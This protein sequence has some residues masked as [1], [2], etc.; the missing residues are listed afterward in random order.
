MTSVVIAAHNEAAVLG[1][2]LDALLAGAAPGEF[3]V[4][5]V[6][7]G[8]T[9]ETVQVAAGRAGVRVVEID[10]ASKPAALNAGDQVAVGFPRIY[11]DADIVLRAEGV[12]ALAAALTEMH[13]AAEHAAAE[14]A[15]GGHGASGH[16]RA[17]LAAVPRRHLDLAGRPLLVRA[18]FAINSRLPAYRDGLFGRG[19]VALSGAGRSRFGDFPELAADDLF[20]DS[21]FGAGEKR[22]VAAVTARVATPRCTRDLVRRLVRVRRGNAAMRAAAARAVVPAPVRAADR[23]AWLREVVL[24][25]PWLAPAAVGYVGITVLAAL[26]ARRPAGPAGWER[27][28]SS[29]S[30]QP[31]PRPRPLPHPQPEP[32]PEP[33]L[34]RREGRS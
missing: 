12:R 28:E 15:A 14:H 25:R 17:P 11:L 6:A 3:D 24:P 13:P 9:D 1:R 33:E 30:P 22:E 23:L 21:L 26:A 31:Q 27:D 10:V 4:T 16:G 19:A 34:T 5:V 7:N 32:E 18:F 2:C 8:C 20:L 29:R